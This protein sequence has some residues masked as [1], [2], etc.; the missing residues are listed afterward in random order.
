MSGVGIVLLLVLVAL[1][2]WLVPII[3]HTLARPCTVCRRIRGSRTK[4]CPGCGS[5]HHPECMPRCPGTAVPEPPR[6]KA[7]EIRILDE[8]SAANLGKCQVC[9]EEM[10]A[11]IVA[12]AKCRTPHHRACWKYNGKCT[13][14]GCT[15]ES[16]T[17]LR[18]PEKKDEILVIEDT[19]RK[20]DKNAVRQW[21]EEIADSYRDGPVQRETPKRGRL[22]LKLRRAG[23]KCT[24]EGKRTSRGWKIRF[25]ARLTEKQ[26]RKLR[27]FPGGDH[28]FLQSLEEDGS[29]ALSPAE[30]PD[31]KDR[32]QAFFDACL[33]V[34]DFAGTV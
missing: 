22:V 8:P 21:I 3:T 29:L 1:F 28:P 18:E 10:K 5:N 34:I 4:R 24:L 12:C 25:R 7:T 19:R 9:G 20:A 17:D 23:V 26:V 14:F 13:T 6:P 27:T 11:D 30:T 32:L 31:R 15:T 33:S 16:Y 2:F